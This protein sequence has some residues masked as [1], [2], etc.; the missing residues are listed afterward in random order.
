[1]TKRK[2]EDY[3]IDKDWSEKIIDD[4]MFYCALTKRSYFRLYYNEDL[5]VTGFVCELCNMHHSVGKN[6]RAKDYQAGYCI[7]ENPSVIHEK[8]KNGSSSKIEREYCHHWPL[9]Y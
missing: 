7:N 5:N 8:Q 9:R 6:S 3:I 1:M 4:P 2:R